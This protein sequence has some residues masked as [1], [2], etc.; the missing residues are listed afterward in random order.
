MARRRGQPPVISAAEAVALVADGDTLLIEGSGGGI[1]EP[2][3]LLAALGERY[4]ETQSPK[5]LTL[6]HTTGI[7]DRAGAGMDHLA[8]P[9]LVRRAVAGNWGMAPEMSRMA[10]AGE[11]E[12][13][14]FP[15]GVMAQMCREMAA[16][17][18]GV[19]THVGLGTFCDPRVDGGK[20]NSR[21]T[22]D[23]VSIVNLH[24]KEWLHYRS[25][26]PTIGFI[27][28][29]TADE[30]GNLSIEHEAARLEVLAIAQAV[31]NNGG[32]VIAQVKRRAAS[33]SL[34]PRTVV[35]PGY[36]VDAVVVVPDQRQLV[37][38]DY[39]PAL[40][41][42]VRGPI[43]G[44]S[45]MPLTPRKVVGRR[46]LQEISY[47]DVVN[48]GVG[49][50]DGVAAVAAEEGC[51]DHFMLTVEQG[52]I[53][54]IPVGGVSFGA[55][56]NPVAII[57]QPAQFDFY[58]GGGLDIAFL[59]FA[60]FDRNGNIN[61]SKF[62][63]RLVGSGGF[64]D[65]T[66]NTKTVCF[67]GTLTA[68]GL[69]VEIGDGRMSIVAEG[70]HAKAVP[71]VEHITFNGRWAAERRQRVLLI[72]ERAVLSFEENG[73]HLIEVAPGVDMQTE[74]LDLIPF[75]VQATEVR[76]MDEI[77]FIDSPMEWKVE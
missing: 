40:S 49:I 70:R 16:R 74:V 26:V 29:T 60:Q 67:C 77:L 72:T 54:G 11:F 68:G 46:G 64:I 7:G 10:L 27:R 14:N 63:G 20:L 65:I 19:T 2:D 3:R 38:Y 5:G 25:Q 21:T 44:V 36:C 58:D 13:Y 76:L 33:G 31:R 35:V 24:G 57:E 23:L 41:G 9:G 39:E 42:E 56:Y 28:A 1:M 8:Q 52:L 12:A 43:S 61:V 15:Q 45:V 48:L 32:T 22:E 17:R 75:P 34:D 18:P 55:S 30:D 59:G 62:N 50:A 6:V 37:E 66:Q 71:E 73:W 53:G 69:E 4:R 51:F 47:D